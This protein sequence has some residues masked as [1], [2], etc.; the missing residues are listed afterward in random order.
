L[1]C[2]FSNTFVSNIIYLIMTKIKLI[3]LWSFV[4]AMST[5]FVQCKKAN[6]TT[7]IV[8]VNAATFSN[9]QQHIFKHSCNSSGCHNVAAASNVQHGLVLEGTDVYER[10]INIDPKNVDAKN[11][12]LKI[13]YPNKSDSSFL[14]HKVDWAN[15]TKYKFGNQMPLGADLLTADEIKYIKQWIDAGA[16]KTGVVADATLIKAH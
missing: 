11:A 12:K 1:L 2:G 3:F 8:D 16:P 9:M 10:I 5:L 4:A 14:F 6:T 7:E 15:N 13:V